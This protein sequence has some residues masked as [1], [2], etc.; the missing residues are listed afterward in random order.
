[1]NARYAWIALA[2]AGAFALAACETDNYAPASAGE[3]AAASSPY[4]SGSTTGTPSGSDKN[5]RGNATAGS[6]PA[7]PAAPS[8]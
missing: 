8:P 5:V 1:M 4:T 2:A 6:A 3:P 7:P